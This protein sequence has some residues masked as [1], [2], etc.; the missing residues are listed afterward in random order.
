M[1]ALFSSLV[2]VA[3]TLPLAGPAVASP[4]PLH[5]QSAEVA[6]LV[7]RGRALIAEGKGA[8]ARAVLEEADAKD[9]GAPRTRV[10]LIRALIEI[11]YLN[12]ALN[13]TDD[14]VGGG[15]EGP[16]PDY[17]FGMAFVYKAR[18]YLREGVGLAMVG[19]HYGDA[20][21]YLQSATAADGERYGDAF[22]PLAE[23]AWNSQ[24][25]EIARA[26]AA[27]AVARPEA[28]S[29][30]W[31]ML[32]EVAFSQFVVANAVEARKEEADGHWQA[33]FDAFTKAVELE[34]RPRDSIAQVGLAKAHKKIGD[35]LVWKA[36]L[37]EAA[38]QYAAAMGWDP[39]SVDY[40]Q[41]LGSLGQEKLLPTLEEGENNFVRC[42]RGERT[43]ADA[44]LLWWLGWARFSAKDY[45]TARTA[46][47]DAYAKWPAYVNCLWYSGLCSFHLG[48]HDAAIEA[49]LENY[50]LDPEDLA[51][52]INSQP[53]F[54]LSILDGLIGNSVNAGKLIE[55]ARLSEAQ[56]TASPDTT[57]Y[58]N[59]AGLFF[60]DAG[61]AL[62][63]SGSEVD[64]ELRRE[65]Y[66][67]ALVGY[68]T[69][70][71]L[72]PD[73]PALLNDTAVVLH[74]NL[75]RELDR[76]LSMYRRAS[77]RAEEELK[78]TDLPPEIRD[79]YTI[80]RRDSRNNLRLLE[81]LLEQRRKEKEERER[82]AREAEKGKEGNGRGEGGRG[83]GG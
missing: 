27:R 12:D 25:L 21:D 55:A 44:T 51:A 50:R 74:Y 36:R 9:G 33:A 2:L 10:W 34:G 56:A 77:E 78:R 17:L 82:K 47:Q 72:E 11:E 58:W 40:G 38:A 53:A 52:S 64:Q 59:N 28:S 63:K 6:E 18:K 71:A 62:E 13:M 69:A 60:R 57:R 19:M 54:H 23:A 16:D 80:A 14:L 66:E 81:R 76:A 83:S 8:E 45:E 5:A 46:F 37:D 24:R 1:N 30:A 42:H 43:S 3:L 65:Y 73:N 49:I 4:P 20:V 68:E 70:L 7:R 26:A 31:M 15:F 75:D 41:L 39:S 61:D 79:L 22:L 32:G 48:Q 29:A 67:K 35:A